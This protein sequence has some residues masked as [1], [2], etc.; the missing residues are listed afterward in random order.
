MWPITSLEMGMGGGGGVEFVA[1]ILH[2][3]QSRDPP[4]PPHTAMSR[5]QAREGWNWGGGD[6]GCGC[7][8]VSFILNKFY[9]CESIKKIYIFAGLMSQ[10]KKYTVYIYLLA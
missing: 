10:L 1:Y 7:S 9:V 2:A 4:P 6:S 8:I 3:A 5:P